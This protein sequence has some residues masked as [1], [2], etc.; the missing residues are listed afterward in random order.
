MGSTHTADF[1]SSWWVVRFID[2]RAADRGSNRSID[3]SIDQYITWRCDERLTNCAPTFGHMISFNCHTIQIFKISINIS[4]WSTFQADTAILFVLFLQRRIFFQFI[5][6]PYSILNLLSGRP[7]QTN[8]VL[9]PV[10]L[11][12]IIIFSRSIPAT[13]PNFNIWFRSTISSHFSN[14]K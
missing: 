4:F 8:T 3:R 7:N 2:S 14:F 10:L 13:V 1:L 11:H 5:R 9:L 6:C 12:Q